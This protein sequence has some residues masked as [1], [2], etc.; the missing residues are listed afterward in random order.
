[1]TR[2]AHFQRVVKIC[3]Y[4]SMSYWTRQKCARH[5]KKYTIAFMDT[6]SP[7]SSSLLIFNVVTEHLQSTGLW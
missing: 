4:N 6:M 5:L 1:M 7:R 2:P 3:Y